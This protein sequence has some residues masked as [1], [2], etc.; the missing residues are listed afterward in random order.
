MPSLAIQGAPALLAARDYLGYLEEATSN[1]TAGVTVAEL[2][3]E[4]SER[5]FVHIINLSP[6]PIYA[7]FNEQVSSVNG[8]LLSANGG[9]LIIN[10][11]D[12]YT[13]STLPIYTIGAVAASQMFMHTMRRFSELSNEDLS[14]VNR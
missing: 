5:V 2:I 13:L 8:I 14:L 12:D 3:K 4:D 7:G 9:F 6:N 1:P 10:S 11:K